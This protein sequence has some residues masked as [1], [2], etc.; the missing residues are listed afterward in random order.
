MRTLL[1]ELRPAALEKAELRDLLRQ[2]ADALRSRAGLT[3]VVE[4]DQACL[5]PPDVKVAFYR[6]AQEALNNVIKH[7]R[8]NQVNVRLR[9]E[10]GAV[11][12]EIA[13]DGKGFDPSEVSGPHRGTAPRA[14]GG[15]GGDGLRIMRERAEAIGA[16]LRVKSEP[17]HG[18]QVLLAWA[19]ES[20]PA[21]ERDGAPTG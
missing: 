1:L 11:E 3:I 2:L 19:P 8:A 20:R 16:H 10:T 9:C 6:I 4:A 5:L 21:Q 13:D 18:T 12:L 7:A 15:V 14:I 17:G